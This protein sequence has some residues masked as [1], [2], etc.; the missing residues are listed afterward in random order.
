LINTSGHVHDGGQ[1]VQ[2]LAD[3]NL[4]CNS[5]ATYGGDPAYIQKPV[6]MGHSHGYGG[7]MKHISRMSIC[8]GDLLNHW[9]VR[10]GQKWEIK[11]SYDYKKDNGM[12]HSD[13]KQDHVMGISILYVEVK[14]EK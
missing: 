5:I 6:A 12:V 10:P 4:S 3:G 2:I 7:A 14:R 11:A 8:S 13:G 9:L 1:N